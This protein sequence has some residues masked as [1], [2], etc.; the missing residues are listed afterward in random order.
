[1]VIKKRQYSGELTPLETDREKEHRKISRKAACE[2]TVL[3]KNDNL[4]PVKVGSRLAIYG[5]DIAHIQK[6]GTGSGDV[7]VRHVVSLMEGLKEAEYQ[8]VNEKA[9]LKFIEDTVCSDE[10]RKHKIWKILDERPGSIDADLL[11][12]IAT[13]KGPKVSPI[14][15]KKED[16]VQTDAA[17]FMISRVAGEAMDRHLDAGDYYLTEEE[18]S[19]IDRQKCAGCHSGRRIKCKR[20]DSSRDIESYYASG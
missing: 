6:G 3:F 20:K 17:I 7:N 10:V 2:G 8:V 19:A 14:P 1:M 5:N 15:V 11:N 16:L 13:T 4:L 9:V 12:L 18:Q